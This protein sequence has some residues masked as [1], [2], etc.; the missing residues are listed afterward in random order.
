MK[1]K[2]KTQKQHINALNHSSNVGKC[3]VM[4]YDAKLAVDFAND[5][6]Q[7]GIYVVGFSFPVV[8]KD[9][10]RIRVQISAAHTPEQVDQC[11]DAFIEIGKIRG[12]LKN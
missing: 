9:K 5:L 3:P 6:L 2:K 8:P 4:L 1:N 10:A 7:K 11:V 12:V